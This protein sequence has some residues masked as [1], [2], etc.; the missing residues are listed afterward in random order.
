LTIQISNLK[1]SPKA[2]SKDK[3][4]DFSQASPPPSPKQLLGEY[5]R[6]INFVATET[7]R[8]DTIQKVSWFLR[9]QGPTLQ[10]PT[11]LL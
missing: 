3:D 11:Y 7:L 4:E 1:H 10:V 2:R 6:T 5:L 9:R 8:F